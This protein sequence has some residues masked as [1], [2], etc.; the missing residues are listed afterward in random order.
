MH[1]SLSL[2]N[3]ADHNKDVPA[4]YKPVLNYTCT[5]AIHDNVP[6]PPP[7]KLE[8]KHAMIFWEKNDDGNRIETLA[9]R[10]DENLPDFNGQYLS[11]VTAQVLF[12]DEI[13][14]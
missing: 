13:L 12:S 10:R 11:N 2:L 4:R 9:L 6:L 5:S 8:P 14:R 7:A 3:I 1:N